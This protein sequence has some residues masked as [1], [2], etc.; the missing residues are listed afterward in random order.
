MRKKPEV[1]SSGFFY[2]G[3][4]KIAVFHF[5]KSQE[6]NWLWHRELAQHSSPACRPQQDWPFAPDRALPHSSK[7]RTL[8]ALFA[9]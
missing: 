4:G 7:A 5:Y 6:G 3:T 2:G 8:S 1:C 9:F